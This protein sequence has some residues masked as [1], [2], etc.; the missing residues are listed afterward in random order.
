ML[1]SGLVLVTDAISAA[2]LEEGN[3]RIGDLEINIRNNCAYILG[4]NTLCGSILPLN[5]CVNLFD[6]FNSEYL[7]YLPSSSAAAAVRLKPLGF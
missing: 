2:G 6:E 7:T 1:G 3:H 5:K 4:T